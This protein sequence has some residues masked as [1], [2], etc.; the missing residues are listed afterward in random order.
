MKEELYIIHY[1]CYRDLEIFEEFEQV[2]PT[3]RWKL[4]KPEGRT[5]WHLEIEVW[6]ER[7]ITIA[8]FF[9]SKKIKEQFPDWVSEDSLVFRTPREEQVFKCTNQG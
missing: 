5:E 6:R 1:R 4:V 3:G 9:R 2:I 7:I 8:R